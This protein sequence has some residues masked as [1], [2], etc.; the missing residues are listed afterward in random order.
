MY[1][2]KATMKKILAFGASNSK[3]SINKKL[4][5]FAVSFFEEPA[6]TLID[7]NDFELPLFGVDLE[8]E[9]GPPDNAVRFSNLLEAHD[10]LI[11]S[12]AEHNSNFTAVFKNLGDW[13]SRLGG[14]T[15]KNKKTFL[16]STSNGG[17]GGKSAMDIA[18]NILPYRGMDI[19]AHFSLPFFSENFKEPDGITD[20]ELLKEF[21]EQLDKFKASLSDDH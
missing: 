18:L 13:V 2:N 7:L 11:I 9:I 4:A 15:W 1:Y 8:A 20:P 12:L 16:L 6:Q 5:H 17:R 3:T 19:K 21:K 14:P 10:G